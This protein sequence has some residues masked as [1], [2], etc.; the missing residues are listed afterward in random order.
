M[1]SSFGCYGVFTQMKQIPLMAVIS[2]VVLLLVGCGQRASDTTAADDPL[3]LF[4]EQLKLEVASLTDE[5]NRLKEASIVYKE[6]IRQRDEE[7]EKL[8]R[9]LSLKTVRPVAKPQPKRYSRY[10]I[11]NLLEGKSRAEVTK[12]LGRPDSQRDSD[13]VN[14]Y[15]EKW[16]YYGRSTNPVTLKPESITVEFRSWKLNE[17]SRV[18][19]GSN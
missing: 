16:Y 18:V 4:N 8:K 3:T 19:C 17:V 11:K 12:L 10:E 6:T 14:L 15:P 1:L 9:Q 13:Q 7:L 2:C 5:V